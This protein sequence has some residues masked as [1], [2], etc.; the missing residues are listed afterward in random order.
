DV[1][2]RGAR[3]AQVAVRAVLEVLVTGVGVDRGHETALD[4]ELLVEDLRERREA[5]RGARGVRDDVVLRGVVVG[6]VHAH[7]ERA[8]LVLA[9]RGDDDLLGTVV[10]VRRGLRRVGEEAGRLDHDVGTEL[11]PRKVRRV[12]LGKRADALAVDRDR[13]VVVGDLTLERA[14][15]RVVLQQVR[16]RLVV[17]Q[18][19]HRDDLDVR[20]QLQDRTK[21]VPAD[22]AEAVDSDADGHN[23]LLGARRTGVRRTVALMWR[24]APRRALREFPPMSP[25]LYR[26]R[27]TTGT[28]VTRR[29]VRA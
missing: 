10:E 26:R 13:L 16:E 2:R 19:V 20:T 29:D 17:G 18:V 23:A 22:A 27:L 8:V 11:A 5:V 1:D 28:L 25:S 24:H 12:T 7:D 3:T 21:V 4:A 15:H 6:V 14:E 9:R